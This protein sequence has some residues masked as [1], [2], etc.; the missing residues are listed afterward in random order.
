M[1]LCFR[2]AG[3]GGGSYFHSEMVLRRRQGGLDGQ[4]KVGNDLGGKCTQASNSYSGA[5]YCE[6]DI[7][8]GI[9]VY[10]LLIF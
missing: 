8:I 2:T 3:W 7:I 1:I 4:G 9:Y 10:R 5:N 6:A